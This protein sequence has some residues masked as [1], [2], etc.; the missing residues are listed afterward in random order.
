VKISR[1]VTVTQIVLVTIDESKFDATFMAEFRASFYPFTTV[2]EHLEHLGQL[3]AR[4]LA[5]NGDFIEGYG[6]A[7]DMGIRF[8][9]VDDSSEI[10]P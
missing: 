7:K 6:P 8:K 9:I 3:F 1:E 4:G 5:D 2:N 10:S